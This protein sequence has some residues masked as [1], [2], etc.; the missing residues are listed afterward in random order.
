MPQTTLDELIEESRKS[1]MTAEEKEEQRRSFVYGN[2]RIENDVITK[3]IV[4]RAADSL[5]AD[6]Q[7]RK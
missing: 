6:E 2:T 3:E 4:D 7:N 5:S 1:T